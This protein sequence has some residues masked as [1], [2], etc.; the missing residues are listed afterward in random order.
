MFAIRI[1]KFSSENRKKPPACFA[2]SGNADST[3]SAGKGFEPHTSCAAY[4][5]SEDKIPVTTQ[6]STEASRMFLRGFSTSSENVEMA[7]KPMYVSTAME[8]PSK[9]EFKLKVAG[10]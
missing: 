4:T 6:T 8:V 9:I 5:S 1:V 3:C 7:S 10:S 2:T